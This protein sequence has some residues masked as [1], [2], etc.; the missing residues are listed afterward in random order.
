[1]WPVPCCTDEK[2][3]IRAPETSQFAAIGLEVYT[4]P[5]RVL[6]HKEARVAPGST[7]HYIVNWKTPTSLDH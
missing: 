4:F 3:G 1:M 6:E 7:S 5:R 2:G